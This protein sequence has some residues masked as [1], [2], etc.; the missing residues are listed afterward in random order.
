MN[1][2]N[3]PSPPK[4]TSLIRTIIWKGVPIR[5][6]LL[7]NLVAKCCKL[8]YFCMYVTPPPPLPSLQV[9]LLILGITT[10]SLVF[11]PV[12][13][14]STLWQLRVR[15][16]QS[17]SSNTSMASLGSLSSHIFGS[18]SRA[19]PGSHGLLPG[20]SGHHHGHHEGGGSR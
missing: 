17:S 5:A 20:S 4:D 10:L 19:S 2:F 14:K 7:Y 13:W 18:Q 15:G 12:I 3:P 1:A 8:Y 9:Y 16:T 6:G 11:A